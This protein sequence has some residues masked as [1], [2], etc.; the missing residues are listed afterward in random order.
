V[1]EAV[2]TRIVFVLMTAPVAGRCDPGTP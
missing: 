1:I 2:R